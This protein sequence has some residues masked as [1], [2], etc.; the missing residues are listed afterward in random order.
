[1]WS[2]LRERHAATGPYLC[3]A[4]SIADAMFTPVAT[5]LRSYG[6]Q[7]S[8]FG[9]RGAAGAY[10]ALLLAQPDYLQWEREA[11]EA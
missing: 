3:G 8:D 10:A 5:R 7:L 6:V 4:W 11:L 9:D 2:D 1:M